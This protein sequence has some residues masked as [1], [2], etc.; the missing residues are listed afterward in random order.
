MYHRKRYI[1]QGSAEIGPRSVRDMSILRK[2]FSHRGGRLS[3]SRRCM[4]A[5]LVTWSAI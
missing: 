1:L 3:S 2:S 4:L 5:G